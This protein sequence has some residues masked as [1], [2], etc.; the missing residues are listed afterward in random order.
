MSF[1]TDNKNK[2]QVQSED[3]QFT[4]S[5]TRFN[6]SVQRGMVMIRATIDNQDATNSLT[7]TKNGNGGTS[8]IVPPNSVAVIENEIITEI[9]I[10]PNA[11]TG[12]GLLS[13]DMTT[14]DILKSGGFA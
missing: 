5:V 1:F 6:P 13:A 12:T 3:T 8:Y 4:T 14:L 7:F 2:P 10:T 11:T 9:T